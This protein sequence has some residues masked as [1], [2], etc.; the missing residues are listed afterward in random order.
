MKNLF[1]IFALYALMLTLLVCG[2]SA[3]TPDTFT[4]ASVADFYGSAALTGDDLMNAINSFSGFYLITTTNP[5]DSANAAFFIYSMVKHEDKYYLQLGLAENQTKANLAANGKGVA[6]YAASPS[7]EE[8]AKPYAMAGSRMRF[9]AVTDEALSKTLNTSGR[10][11]AM[12]YE[13]VEFRPL[14]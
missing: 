2:A 3:E 4:S 12:F 5:D 9:E 14:G 10:D 8:G 7:T 11:G 1:K 6:V 13:V